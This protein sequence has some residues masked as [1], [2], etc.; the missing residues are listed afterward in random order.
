MREFKS[1]FK[2]EWVEVVK[3]LDFD[4]EL[5]HEGK[6]ILLL[7]IVT[8]EDTIYCVVRKEFCPPYMFKETDN[9][10]WYTL[11]SGG[12]E[13]EEALLSTIDRELLEEAGLNVKNGDII[14][15]AKNI[16]L[17]KSTDYRSSIFIYDIDDYSIE[18]A[19]GDG[20]ECEE[21]SKSILI[22]LEEWQKILDVED[23]Y[24]FLFYSGYLILKEYLRGRN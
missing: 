11:L 1:L 7:P 8:Y 23:H 13:N 17:C 18:E 20:T 6:G 24:D 16:P 14:E 5:F 19:E 22:T 10:L 4:Y 12:I 21:K 3:P 9:N 2:G 15:V